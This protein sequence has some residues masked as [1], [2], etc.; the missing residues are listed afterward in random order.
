MTGWVPGAGDKP[1]LYSSPA[2][3]L[4][5]SLPRQPLRL[6]ATFGCSCAHLD[7]TFRGYGLH[8]SFI[9]ETF[10]RGKSNTTMRRARLMMLAPVCRMYIPDIRVGVLINSPFRSGRTS[11]QFCRSRS[12]YGIRWNALRIKP[13]Q[14]TCR[15]QRL[16]NV[17]LWWRDTTRLESRIL[18]VFVLHNQP[19]GP[20][21]EPPNDRPRDGS[22]LME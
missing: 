1:F 6:S 13:A 18:V 17:I 21:H 15:T 19:H 12:L 14:Q 9:S 4:A 10:V 11:F 5:F 20:H 3:L 16:M 7:Q 8:H 2:I 22:S